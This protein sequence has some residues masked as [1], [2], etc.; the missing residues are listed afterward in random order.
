MAHF[1]DEKT[2]VKRVLVFGQGHRASWDLNLSR[3]PSIRERVKDGHV[4]RRLV[5]TYTSNYGWY[6]PTQHSERLKCPMSALSN[7]VVTSLMAVWRTGNEARVTEGLNFTLISL[8]LS[9]HM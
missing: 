4:I 7:T 9:R 2:D 3:V 8:Y 5:S 1:A 6:C